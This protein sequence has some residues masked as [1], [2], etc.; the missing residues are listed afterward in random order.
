[1]TAMASKEWNIIEIGIKHY[2]MYF[3]HN[4]MGKKLP[5]CR[6]N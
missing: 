2:K 4:Q 5:K 6:N 1:M 3:I